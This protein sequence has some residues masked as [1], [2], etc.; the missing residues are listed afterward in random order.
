MKHFMILS[1]LSILVLTGC[2]KP[3]HEVNPDF[4]GYWEGTDGSAVFQL[5]INSNS[6]ATYV[7]YEGAT[8]VNFTGTAR[9]NGDESKLSIGA[10]KLSIDTPPTYDSQNQINY[11]V[12]D[13][14]T[15]YGN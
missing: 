10:K 11:M 9:I 1:I 8:T 7:K 13:G 5:N 12:L 3:A 14:V 15:Y 4:V 2:G 6:S